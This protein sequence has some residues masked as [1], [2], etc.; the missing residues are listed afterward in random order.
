MRKSKLVVELLVVAIVSGTISLYLF[1]MPLVRSIGAIQW[2]AANVHFYN[3]AY[4]SRL[5]H[6]GILPFWTSHI[7]AGFPQIADLQVAILY[8]INLILVLMREF[9]PRLML[10]QITMHY[11]IAAGG[12]FLLGRYLSKS[13]WFGMIAAVSY[14]FGGF[15]IGHASHVGMQNAAAWLPLFVVFI[16]FGLQ[17]RRM[18]WAFPAGIVFGFIILTGHFQMALYSA[19]GVAWM[20]AFFF[21]LQCVKGE[22]GGKVVGAFR[23]IIFA[24]LVYFIGVGVS[25]LQLLPTFELTSQSQRA[26]LSLERSQTESLNPSSLPALIE[27]NYHNVASGFYFGPWDRTQNY[28]FVGR[29]ILILALAGA[30]LGLLRRSFRVLVLTSVAFVAVNLLYA[31]GQFAPVQSLFYKFVPFFDKV[32][33]P[34]NMMLLVEIGLIVLAAC[35]VRI[36]RTVYE[37]SRRK[38]AVEILLVFFFFV[39]L[40]E[41]V[42]AVKGNQL[43]FGANKPE[44]VVRASP[45]YSQVL[46]EY[47]TLDALHRFRV[48]RVAAPN[49]N[50]GQY[51]GIDDFAG[52]NPLTPSRNIQYQETMAKNNSLI[53]LAGIK[54]LPCDFGDY[55]NRIQKKVLDFCAVNDYFP[56]AFLVGSVSYASDPQQA[57]NMIQHIDPSK[58]AV[59]E[60]G[61]KPQILSPNPL[62][63]IQSEEYRPGFMRLRVYTTGPQFL[64]IDESYYPGWRAQVDGKE[65]DIYRVDYLFQGLFIDPGIHEV[66]FTF[67]PRSLYQGA[68]ISVCTWIVTITA[69]IISFKM[70]AK[71]GLTTF[72]FCATMLS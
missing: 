9:S 52:Y 48:Y 56:R 3:L 15:M 29:I 19:Y 47:A 44:D 4:S 10:F 54:Y 12:A 64:V 67:Q 46:S 65:E 63:S 7:F 11:V 31:L 45:I 13:F 40:F 27:P 49:D 72:F 34:S 43:L 61:G 38:R 24:V 69:L 57:L 20:F 35:G 23:V 8:P 41:V 26:E 16:L 55:K 51:L 42:G 39:T 66:V 17:K 32:R 70:D 53:N 50:S 6:Q 62:S 25:A 33:A 18:Y 5:L 71:R 1:G 58:I 68:L 14:A 21:V 37:N 59:I 2:D 36:L 60:G 28:L 22:W 30:I